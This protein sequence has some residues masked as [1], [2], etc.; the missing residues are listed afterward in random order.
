MVI[1][2]EFLS[3]E[4]IAVVSPFMFYSLAAKR[5][6]RLDLIWSDR[7]MNSPQELSWYIPRA[8]ISAR[9]LFSHPNIFA[10]KIFFFPHEGEVQ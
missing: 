9:S 4:M 10:F 5:P 1:I 8:V 3:M 6:H 2:F 7:G